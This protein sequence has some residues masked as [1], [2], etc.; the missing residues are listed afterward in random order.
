MKAMRS[1]IGSRDRLTVTLFLAGL[2]HLILILGNKLSDAQLQ[3]Q[4]LELMVAS[5]KVAK[6]RSRTDELVEA[7]AGQIHRQG[8]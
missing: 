6:A 1:T 3:R 4:G 8:R 2:F 5:G 7:I